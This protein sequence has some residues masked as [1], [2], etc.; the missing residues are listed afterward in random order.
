MEMDS[1]DHLI[2]REKDSDVAV[3]SRI[4]GIYRQPQQSLSLLRK[5][6]DGRR[7]PS[8]RES[9]K[10]VINKEHNYER[11]GISTAS[12]IAR[13]QSESSEVRFPIPPHELPPPPPRDGQIYSNNE[14]KILGSEQQQRPNFNDNGM[15]ILLC[16]IK[17]LRKDN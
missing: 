5:Q 11:V 14:I 9:G 2:R 17:A 15:L 12:S 8:A 10:R 16:S 13:I 1:S 3:S 6:A 7:P 4:S